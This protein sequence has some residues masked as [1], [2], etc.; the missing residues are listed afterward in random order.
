MGRILPAIPKSEIRHLL[1]E[2]MS[3]RA[4]SMQSKSGHHLIMPEVQKEIKGVF[5]AMSAEAPIVAKSVVRET[6]LVNR[7]SNFALS[8][9]TNISVR[10]GAELSIILPVNCCAIVKSFV[11]TAKVEAVLKPATR[12]RIII[13]LA[14]TIWEPKVIHKTSCPKRK[15]WW[16]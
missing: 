13:W 5:P 12:L 6:T 4:A 15:I 10:P 3:R 9:R 1:K 2:V 16:R 14:L 7:I 11:P 8:P